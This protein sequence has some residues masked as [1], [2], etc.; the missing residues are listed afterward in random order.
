MNVWLGYM[1]LN[2]C[3]ILILAGCCHCHRVVARMAHVQESSQTSINVWTASA[4]SLVHLNRVLCLVYKCAEQR[5]WFLSPVL[6]SFVMKGKQIVIT[7][8]SDIS[9]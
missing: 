5:P 2:L 3:H 8:L 7:E 6:R 4:G 1:M 9:T